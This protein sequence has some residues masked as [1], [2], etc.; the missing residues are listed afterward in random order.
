MLCSVFIVNNIML[1]F[2]RNDNNP[3]LSMIAMML[4][5]FSN[6][7][8]DY[9]FMFPLGMGMFGAAFA[10]CLAPIISM[11]VLSIHFI[12]KRNDFRYTKSKMVLSSM[13]DVLSLGL[14]SFISEVSSSIVL[15]T[16]NL[17]ILGLKGNLGVASYGIVANIA[18]VGIAVFTGIAQGIQPIV[19]KEYGLKN[20]KAIGKVLKFALITSLTVA[21]TI[22]LSTFFNSDSIIAVFNSEQNPEIAQI[23]KTGLRIYFIGFFFAGINLIMAMYLSAVE[24]AK[25]AFFI[26]IA[27]GCIIIVPLVLLLSKLWQMTGVW[28]S[29]VLTESIVT[30][31]SV[32]IFCKKKKSKN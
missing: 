22:Y 24:Q 29:F 4:G 2:I 32:F 7:I 1:A 31:V 15:I 8:L 12:K 17:A 10:T 26:S 5:S 23:S 18:L 27:R 13:C 25:H 9:V 16:F 30:F 19:S 11:G 20:H 6:I 3:N 28:M 21:T 14:S